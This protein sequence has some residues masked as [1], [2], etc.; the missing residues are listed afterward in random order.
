MGRWVKLLYEY[1]AGE[2]MGYLAL[3]SEKPSE[4]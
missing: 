2:C 4:Q 1:D 3:V